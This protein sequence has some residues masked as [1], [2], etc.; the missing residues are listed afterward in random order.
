MREKAT[1][2]EA[3]QEVLKKEEQTL[4]E[5]KAAL[6]LEEERRKKIEVEI[7][8]LKEQVSR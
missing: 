2:I 8:E 3:L 5:L 4:I 6:A 1:K 7:V